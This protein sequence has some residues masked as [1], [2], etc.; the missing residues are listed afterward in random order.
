MNAIAMLHDQINAVPIKQAPKTAKPVHRGK[1][2]REQSASTAAMA[3]QDRDL[4]R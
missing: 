2:D 4:I 3:I 1:K